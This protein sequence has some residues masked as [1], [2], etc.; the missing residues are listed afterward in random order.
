MLLSRATGSVSRSDHL[1]AFDVI[2]KK[3][4]EYCYHLEAMKDT[5]GNTVILKTFVTKAPVAGALQN[6]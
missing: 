3:A 2:A 1:F 5:R 4:G 6:W